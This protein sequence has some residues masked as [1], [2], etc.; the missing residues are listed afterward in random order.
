[1]ISSSIGNRGRSSSKWKKVG[2]NMMKTPNRS[3]KLWEYLQ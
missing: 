3:A 1:M 2:T